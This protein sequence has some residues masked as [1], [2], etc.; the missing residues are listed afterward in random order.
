[1]NFD[2]LQTS[3][4]QAGGTEKSQEEL[5]TMTKVRHHPTLRRIRAKLIVE[6]VLLTA[7]IALYNNAFDGDTKP[8]WAN[9]ILIASAFVFIANDA[10][11]YL[12]LQRLPAEH[13]IRQSME[14]FLRKL[15]RLS[16]FSIGSS[17]LFGTAVILF[18]ASG[19]HGTPGT[20][21]ALAGMGATLLGTVYISY[22]NWNSRIR[23]FQ[24]AVQEL[25]EAV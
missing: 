16:V 7:F 24:R 2:E 9:L 25:G 15:Q 4:Q 23:H 21:L 13:S 20:Y 12:A 19:I 3:W 14:N 8:W 17:L 11:G 6:V 5:R 1:M 18:F 22:K 10:V